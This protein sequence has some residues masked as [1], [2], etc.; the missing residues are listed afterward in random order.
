MTSGRKTY[1][2]TDRQTFQFL[3]IYIL[4]KENLSGVSKNDMK[5]DIFKIFT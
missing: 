5:Y 2:H 4:T 3:D 1:I